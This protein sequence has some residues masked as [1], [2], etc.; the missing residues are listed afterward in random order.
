[1]LYRN[2]I[3]VL[4]ILFLDETC[5]YEEYVYS[6]AIPVHMVEGR[7]SEQKRMIENIKSQMHV[8]ME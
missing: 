3:L 1:M 4:G 8:W 7:Y 2:S 6:S 5:M